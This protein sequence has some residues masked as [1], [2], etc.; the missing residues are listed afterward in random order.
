VYLRIGT[1]AEA[2]ESEVIPEWGSYDVTTGS[3][4]ALPWL[5]EFVT[6]SGIPQAVLDTFEQAS[7]DGRLVLNETAVRD[8]VTGVE[9]DIASLLRE[10]GHLPTSE[11]GPLRVSGDAST[12]VAAVIGPDPLAEAS[13]RVLLVT[14]WGW[15]PMARARV[16]AVDEQSAVLVDVDPDDVAGPWTVQVERST[17]PDLGMAST[18]WEL[19][20]E[21]HLTQGA[22]N[23]VRIDLPAGVY[24]VRVPER[25]EHRGYIS[26]GVWLAE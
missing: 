13:A 9:V 19:L 1:Q 6:R 10:A 24:R 3:V 18:D 25:G 2:P 22:G 14:G 8:V 23:T 5:R 16:A 7:A 21:S 17:E 12:I 11:W 4:T 20:P 26:E 15:A